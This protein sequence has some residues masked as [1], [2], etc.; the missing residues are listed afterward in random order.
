MTISPHDLLMYCGALVL[1]FIT[2]GPVL[3]AL[4]ARAL[5]GGF[6]AA[7]P[8]AIGEAWGDLLW[9]LCAVFGL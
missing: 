4:A 1:L 9:P 2:P 3:V 6:R 7:W 8:L 5:S